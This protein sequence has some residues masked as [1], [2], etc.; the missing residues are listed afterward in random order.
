MPNHSMRLQ[1]PAVNS[2]VQDTDGREVGNLILRN[3]PRAEFNE[4]SPSLEFVRLNLRQVLHEAGETKFAYRWT[5]PDGGTSTARNPT[6][7][8]AG[9]YFSSAV[10]LVVSDSHG[11]QT[12]TVNAITVV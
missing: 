1:K 7:V 5:F 8:F 11:S 3:L 12:R 4:I 6:H 9:S 2:S 10:T